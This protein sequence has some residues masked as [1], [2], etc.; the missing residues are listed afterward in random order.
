MFGWLFGEEEEEVVK[1]EEKVVEKVE[2]V[3]SLAEQKRKEKF[4]EPLIYNEEKDTVKV[5][6]T[7]KPVTAK[8]PAPKSSQKS[9]KAQTR[10]FDNTSDY[11]L[12]DIISPMSGLVDPASKGDD[13]QAPISKKKR[14][15]PKKDEL[16]PVL[17]PFYGMGNVTEEDEEADKDKT[18]TVEEVIETTEETE[19]KEEP[20]EKK[21]RA[22]RKKRKEVVLEAP[23]DNDKPV[24][25][26]KVIGS[27]EDR[28]RNIA[29]ISEQTQDDLKIIEER[30][31]K[32]RLIRKKD[33]S[34]IDE[35]DDNMSLDELMTLYEKKFKD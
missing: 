18:E 8:K 25:S 5:E 23:D 22:P 15:R 17:S 12:V 11:K 14:Y 30:T 1:K 24:D 6:E 21:K 26:A 9:A 2:T 29:T 27:V 16:V 7:K 33:E 19:V 13:G 3:D 32:F 35:I 34:L 28:L 20:K 10:K 31:G 4:S